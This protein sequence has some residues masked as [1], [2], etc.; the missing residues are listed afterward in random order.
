M[1]E[2]TILFEPKAPD[3]SGIDARIA[4]AKLLKLADKYYKR[5][6]YGLA[7]LP[8]RSKICVLIAGR[9]YREIGNKLKAENYVYWEKR[10]Y[11][12]LPDKVWIAIK[13][14]FSLFTN[15]R[16]WVLQSKY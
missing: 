6:E 7:Y 12:S 4:C 16:Y 1:Y 14:I 8:F 3:K 13:A 9:S 5:S 2:I 15:K 10:V 11:T